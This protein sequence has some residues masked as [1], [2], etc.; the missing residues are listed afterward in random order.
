MQ[1]VCA[2]FMSA[3]SHACVAGN[4]WHAAAAALPRMARCCKRAT[5]AARRHRCGLRA[6]GRRHCRT[7]RAAVCCRLGRDAAQAMPLYLPTRWRLKPASVCMMNNQPVMQLRDMLWKTWMR[8]LL[9]SS[10]CMPPVDARHVHDSLANG[11]ICKIYQSASEI[12][13]Y[14]VLMPALDE[15]HLLDISIASAWQR[16]GLGEKLLGELLA[17]AREVKFARVILEVRPP[18]A[19]P[20]RCTARPD[21]AKL[22]CGAL[23]PG[24]Q[25]QGGCHRHGV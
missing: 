5:P 24:G 4:G 11:Y 25:R 6:A 21:S 17:L 15:V 13:G 18:I 20:T 1:T 22:A 10:R 7:R 9:S 3:A 23:L 19:L 14:A 2:M 8:L 12:V 16:K